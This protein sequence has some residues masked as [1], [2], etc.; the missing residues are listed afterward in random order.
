MAH[1]SPYS[2]IKHLGVF[3]S[4]VNEYGAGNIASH[5]SFPAYYS[6]YAAHKFT[7]DDAVKI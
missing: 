2:N 7:I 3:E 6:M 5:L 1:Y 4:S